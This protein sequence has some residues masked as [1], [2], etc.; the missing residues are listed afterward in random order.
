MIT[1]RLLDARD[2]QRFTQLRLQAIETS[3]T[4]IWP[5]W[6]DQQS[7]PRGISTMKNTCSS[8]WMIGYV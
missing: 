6:Q 2:A 1:I 7:R 5:T 4:A 3:P 8:G